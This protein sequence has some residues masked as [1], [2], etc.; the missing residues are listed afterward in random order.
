MFAR[1]VP[2]LRHVRPWPDHWRSLSTAQKDKLERYLLHADVSEN[3][4]SAYHDFATKQETLRQATHEAQHSDDME[5]RLL[6]ESSL[7]DLQRDVRVSHGQL[8][9]HILGA[10]LP[11]T[12][13]A[14]L[15]VLAQRAG[16]DGADF[17]DFLLRM[18]QGLAGASS[19][20]T[21]VLDADPIKISVPKPISTGGI[22]Y[23]HLVLE[24][25]GS[26]A[27]DLLQFERGVHRLTVM[28]W[29]GKLESTDVRVLV[30]PFL[31]C[32][33][34]L[35][36]ELITTRLFLSSTLLTPLR[37]PRRYTCRRTYVSIRCA[38]LGLE[39]NM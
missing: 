36:A 39:G 14:I 38:H 33:I 23:R 24:V 16:T 4:R 35:C 5:L 1:L 11:R 32:Q 27:W 31:A 37:A 15:E 22:G 12:R 3:A 17:S 26:D 28:S 30:R 9:E 25:V 8:L 6:F 10:H 13:G 21:R 2:G 19:W 18:W 7:P 29:K 34:S 20:K